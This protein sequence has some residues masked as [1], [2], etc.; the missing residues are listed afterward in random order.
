M[1]GEFYL[2]CQ[3]ADL[4]DKGERVTGPTDGMCCGFVGAGPTGE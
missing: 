4:V 2:F 3:L 1:R